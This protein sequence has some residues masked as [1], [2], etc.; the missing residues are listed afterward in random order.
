LRIRKQTTGDLFE[1][2]KRKKIVSES[3]Q[4]GLVDD[5][6]ITISSGTTSVPG[7]KIDWEKPEPCMKTIEQ[8]SETPISKL[9]DDDL[10]RW[11]ESYSKQIGEKSGIPIKTPPVDSSMVSEFVDHHEQSMIGVESIGKPFE[12]PK[13]K[14]NWIQRLIKAIFNI[15]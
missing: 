14:L 13:Q 5:E 3:I 12:K 9:N 4:R 2:R 8:I 10:Q 11:H 6:Q 7:V 1:R 15:K